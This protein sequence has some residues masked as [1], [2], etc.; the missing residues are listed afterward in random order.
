MLAG[1]KCIFYCK[2]VLTVSGLKISV[3]DCVSYCF[4]KECPGWHVDNAD[5]R[6]KDLRSKAEAAKSGTTFKMKRLP[7]AKRHPDFARCESDKKELDAKLKS[8]ELVTFY[9][10]KIQKYRS[11]IFVEVHIFLGMILVHTC[12]KRLSFFLRKK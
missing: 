12:L 1:I 5:Q 7:P 9:N 6:L 2:N 3:S 4:G 11:K 8:G 10:S